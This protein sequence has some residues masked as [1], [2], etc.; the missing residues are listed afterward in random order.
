MT[1]YGWFFVA[2]KKS[3]AILLPIVLCQQKSHPRKGGLMS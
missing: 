2:F 1:H 3:A